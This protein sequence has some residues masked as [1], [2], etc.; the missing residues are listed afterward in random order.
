MQAADHPFTHGSALLPPRAWTPR[1]EAS[2]Q[3][4]CVLLGEKKMKQNT[5]VVACVCSAAREMEHGYIVGYTL[6]MV[7]RARPPPLAWVPCNSI[8]R[9]RLL[10]SWIDLGT[11]SPAGSDGSPSASQG[12]SLPYQPIPTAAT[13]LSL[14]GPGQPHAALGSPSAPPAG[15]W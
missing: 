1:T 5:G 11:E 2:H 7:S 12:H 4:A 10:P 13:S 8:R 15:G 14:G 6:V 3:C 9:S